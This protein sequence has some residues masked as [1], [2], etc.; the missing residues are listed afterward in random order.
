MAF[1][2]EFACNW[3]QVYENLIDHYHTAILHNNMTVEGVDAAL[4]AGASFGG[5]WGELPVINWQP[6]HDGHGLIFTAGRRV[7]DTKVWIRIS[8]MDFPNF[9]TNAALAPSAARQRHSD[10]AMTRW[11]VPVDDTNSI[12]FG[13]RHFND[14]VD[15]DHIGREEDCGVDKID[16]LIGQTRH[17]SYDEQQRVPGDYEAI[18]SQGAGGVAIHQLEHPGRSDVGVYLCRSLLRDA[19]RGKTG[20]DPTRTLSEGGG[21]PRARYTS[22]TVVEVAKLADRDADRALIQERADQVLAV[23]K[24]AEHVASAERRKHVLYRLDEIDGGLG[25]FDD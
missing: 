23:M 21:D 15:P 20:P 8:E 10:V 1:S 7:S 5:G 13:W 24:E 11:Q 18:T 12:A 22:D 19:L 9:C 16:F 14:E 3:L 6:V 25:S 17:R 4:A 2:N